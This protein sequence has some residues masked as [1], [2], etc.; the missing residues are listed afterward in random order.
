MILLPAWA[1]SNYSTPF[2]KI[3]FKRKDIASGKYSLSEVKSMEPLDVVN[4]ILNSIVSITAI[5]AMVIIAR[6]FI[7]KR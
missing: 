5:I 1:P 6:G 2:T 4:K 3:S 7:R